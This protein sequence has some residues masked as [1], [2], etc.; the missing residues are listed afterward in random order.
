MVNQESDDDSCPEEHR[1][2]GLL[3]QSAGRNGQLFSVEKFFPSVSSALFI[4]ARPRRRFLRKNICWTESAV[5]RIRK[6]GYRQTKE[7]NDGTANRM[8]QW[9]EP[10][11]SRFLC[12]FTI[13]SQLLSREQC[14]APDCQTSKCLPCRSAICSVVPLS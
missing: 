13:R 7:N 10:L 8:R 1:D 3:L 12:L 14:E 11:F 2:E 6:S 4:T 5:R 9:A